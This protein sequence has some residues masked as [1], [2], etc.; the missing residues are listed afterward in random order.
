MVVLNETPTQ[1]PLS[2]LQDENREAAQDLV[3]PIEHK[4]Q[5][6]KDSYGRTLL[7]RGINVCGSSKLPTYPYPGSTHL[8]DEKLFWDHR[9][10]SFVN[11]PF[12]LKDAPEHLSRLRA[13]GLTLI[14]LIVTW[15]ALEHEG[16]GIYD[17]SYID[18]LRELLK[19]MPSYGM[20]CIIDPHQDTVKLY[21]VIAGSITN[22]YSRNKVV[23]ILGW[24]GCPWMDI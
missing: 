12:S 22:I 24:L 3:D 20:K 14:R 5:Y 11:R 17:E 1:T 7:M 23:A 9:N 2:S 21:Y 13:W 10:V 4:G 18:Y 16:P 19:L 8:Y 6:F 15:E